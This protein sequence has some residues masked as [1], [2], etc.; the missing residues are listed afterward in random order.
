MLGGGGGGGGVYYVCYRLLPS[1]CEI[2]MVR[3][4]GLLTCTDMH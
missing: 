3:I 1:N 4:T 2:M